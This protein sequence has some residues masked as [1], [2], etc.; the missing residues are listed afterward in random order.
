MKHFDMCM[1]A[2]HIL[3]KTVSIW[4]KLFKS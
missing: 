2:C 3:V 1:T 4:A